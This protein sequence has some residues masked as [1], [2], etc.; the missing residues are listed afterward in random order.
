MRFDG[1]VA[2]LLTW[3]RFGISFLARN[4]SRVF[5]S[6]QMER[7]LQ[8]A[9]QVV[10]NVML[11][12]RLVPGGGALEMALAQF[13]SEKSKVDLFLLYLMKFLSSLAPSLTLFPLFYSFLVARV[14]LECSSGHT[15]PSGE[16][17]K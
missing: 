11:D 1:L 10:R 15:K 9:M 17:W 16:H 3:P 2:L 4:V 14:L 5:F 7:N 8:D 13:L 6:C 12:P